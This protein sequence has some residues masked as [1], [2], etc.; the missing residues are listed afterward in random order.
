[1]SYPKELESS[2]WRSANITGRIDYGSEWF[3]KYLKKK[4]EIL[5]LHGKWVQANS[6]TFWTNGTNAIQFSTTQAHHKQFV[7]SPNS[8]R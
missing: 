1:M 5:A 2:R 6:S 4:T 7:L 8:P 3:Y